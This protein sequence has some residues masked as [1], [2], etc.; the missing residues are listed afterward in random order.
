MA[1][2][3]AN[4]HDMKLVGP[5]RKAMRVNRPR[6]TAANPQHMCMD[7]GYDYPEIRDLIEAKKYVA[8]LKARGEEEKERKKNKRFRARRWVV[9]RTHSWLNRF[10]KI[11]VRFEKRVENYEGLLH[12][13]CAV[14]AFRA[15]GVLG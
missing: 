5:T 12:I 1:V 2:D 4:R 11:L 7:K 9:E 3:G 10:R 13:A 14:I 8:H 15:A 6:P